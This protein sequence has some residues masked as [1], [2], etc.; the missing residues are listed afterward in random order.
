M[1]IV[2]F[3]E[4]LVFIVAGQVFIVVLIV[5]DSSGRLLMSS[6]ITTGTP[7]SFD[8]T[9]HPDEEQTFSPRNDDKQF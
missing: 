7:L 8:G 2:V 3:R 4:K 6:Q 1:F 9:R 5:A